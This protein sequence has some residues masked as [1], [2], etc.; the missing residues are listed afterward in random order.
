MVR[1]RKQYWFKGYSHKN[2]QVGKD[3]NLG[4]WHRKCMTPCLA[5]YGIFIVIYCHVGAIKI[6]GTAKITQLSDGYKCSCG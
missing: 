2:V 1:A 4:Y 6:D 5:Y 3:V